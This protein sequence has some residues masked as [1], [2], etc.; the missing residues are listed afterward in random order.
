VSVKHE[1][2]P[3]TLAEG[4]AAGQRRINLPVWSILVGGGALGYLL[5]GLTAWFFVP[6]LG[7]VALAAGWWVV[8]IPRWWAWATSQGVDP[9]DLQDV[10]EAEKL[11]WPR[12]SWLYRHGGR[13][14]R[15]DRALL[16]RVGKE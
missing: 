4:I 5:F 13:F 6:F 12:G 14:W 7:G 8:A 3:P 11:V 15:H 16:P 9:D 10:A 1:H 2:A